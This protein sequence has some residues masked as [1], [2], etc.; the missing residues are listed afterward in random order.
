MGRGGSQIATGE[1]G[2]KIF[3]RALEYRLSKA[4]GH[5]DRLVMRLSTCILVDV[6]FHRGPKDELELPMRFA[7]D[8]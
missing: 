3:V 6:D 4:D 1:R 7:N 2:T 5:R 8:F